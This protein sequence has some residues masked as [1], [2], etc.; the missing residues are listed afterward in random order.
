V[1]TSDAIKLAETYQRT[2]HQ[3]KNQID[4][5]RKVEHMT[6][7]RIGVLDGLIPQALGIAKNIF[8]SK[9]ATIVEIIV[10]DF[11]ALEGLFF[12]AELE[13]L[14]SSRSPGQR[15]YSRIRTL[16]YQRLTPVGPKTAIPCVTLFEEK[17]LHKADEPHLLSNSLRVKEQWI[18]HFGGHGNLPSALK[19]K[20]ANASDDIEVWVLGLDHIPETL[21]KE[22]SELSLGDVT[23]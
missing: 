16:G 22:V 8:E 5:I 14:I 13:F 20:P 10:D 17:S 2:L 9:S 21:W 15:K 3:F 6:C 4:E 7:V 18:S 1:W 23:P 19:K 11:A 12:K